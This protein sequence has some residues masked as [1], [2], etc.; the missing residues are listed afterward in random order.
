MRATVLAEIYGNDG[1]QLRAASEKVRNA[2]RSTY[3]M[4]ETTTTEPTDIPEARFEVD[5][6]KASLAGV[7]P[8]EAA[9]ALRRYT[10][11]E[12][13]GYGHAP[14]ERTAQPV[15][16]RADYGNKVDP[17]E[18]GGLTV[19]NKLGLDVPLSELVRVTHTTAPRPI[20][21]KDGTRVVLVGGELGNS[22]PA[23][24][25]LDLNH[26]LN[27]MP[28]GNGDRLATGNLGLTPVRA[29]LSRAPVQL[30]WDGEIRM[31]LDCYH[32]L[33]IALSC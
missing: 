20:L 21:N 13:V 12:T 25:V 11:G 31:T 1:E 6:E 19:K 14:G 24:A 16:L 17:A 8:A 30:L 15:I 33:F 2:F 5:Q 26:R 18:L 32:D 7:F 3:D 29:D 22:V 9:L 4:V 23:Y 28:V 27:G 10:A